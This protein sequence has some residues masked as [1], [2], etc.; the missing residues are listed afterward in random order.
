MYTK[1]PPYLYMNLN[2]R[3]STDKN[4]ITVMTHYHV[5]CGYSFRAVVVDRVL[6]KEKKRSVM[7]SEEG[8]YNNTSAGRNEQDN[9]QKKDA[10]RKEFSTW[11]VEMRDISCRWR[12]SG[13]QTWC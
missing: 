8:M 11:K 12:C 10:Q 7:A 13:Q 4:L 3:N 5:K 6:W 1:H 2:Q 9:S